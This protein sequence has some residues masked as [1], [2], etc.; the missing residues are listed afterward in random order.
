MIDVVYLKLHTGDDIIGILT[1]DGLHA[2]VISAPM[3]VTY[4]GIDKI[5]MSPWLPDVET[6]NVDFICDFR[7]EHIMTSIIAPKYLAD[8]YLKMREG[9]INASEEYFKKTHNCD[10]DQTYH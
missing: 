10:E 4:S 6:L 7:S 8:I 1:F 3:L 9:Y 2:T 5:V